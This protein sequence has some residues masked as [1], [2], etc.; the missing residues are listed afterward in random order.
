MK[1]SAVRSLL[2]GAPWRD[3]TLDGWF[4]LPNG[5]GPDVALDEAFVAERPQMDAFFDVFAENWHQRT[6]AARSDHA[7]SSS[8]EADNG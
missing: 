5:P 4:P 3:L 2:L 8:M 7:Q 1:T 6:G